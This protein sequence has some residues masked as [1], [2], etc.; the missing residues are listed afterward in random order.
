LLLRELNKKGLTFLNSFADFLLPRLCP[1]CKNK[2]TLHEHLV[3]TNCLSKIR[4]ASADQLRMEFNR[5]FIQEKLITDFCSLFVFEK[6]K[7]LQ[8]IA[9]ELKYNGRFKIGVHLG[10]LV[11]TQL[12]DTILE[13]NPDI[14]VPVPLHPLKKAERGYNQSYFIAQ[15]IRSEL[16][17]PVSDRIIRRKRFTESQTTMT[18]I[19]RKQNIK[20]AFQIIN[21]NKVCGKKIILLDDIITTGATLSECASILLDSNADKIFA[22]SVAIAN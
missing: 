15:G 12:K 3:C 7:E 14:I 21:K 4:Y 16:K 1:S 18:L 10:K 19:E 8:A 6:D 20:G 11:A 13:W 9:H 22:L 5:K 17:I 2:L